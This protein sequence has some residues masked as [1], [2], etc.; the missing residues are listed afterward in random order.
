M[1]A[2]EPIVTR[3]LDGL[4]D[5]L[6][7]RDVVDVMAEL[8]VPLTTRVICELLGVPREV[9]GD[10]VVWASRVSEKIELDR[11]P[12]E[13]V[14]RQVEATVALR[15]LVTE[16][17]GERRT[18]PRHDLL[19]TFASAAI[20]G[21]QLTDAELSANVALLM[22]SAQETSS[23]LIGN[24]LVALFQHPDQLARLR[25]DPSIDECAIEELARYDP[26]AQTRP[27]VAL[28]AT[29]I[30]G[31]PIQPGEQVLVLLG[32]ANR[33]ERAFAKPDALDVTRYPNHH[34]AFGIGRHLCFGANLARLEARVAVT[35][36]I[37]QFPDA[38]PAVRR[39]EHLSRFALRRPSRL[40]LRLRSS[41]AA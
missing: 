25:D 7:D 32:A 40:P 9:E 15:A 27:R 10:V 6:G 5:E 35:R 13:A 19:S 33:D 41:R 24:G 30:G 23:A 28:V 12:P 17:V 20:G 38:R 2:I 1:P 34:L 29:E 11:G 36:V 4:L 16:L 22:M 8:A 31:V 39:F 21:R 14:A 37:R 18:C 3:H 26:P